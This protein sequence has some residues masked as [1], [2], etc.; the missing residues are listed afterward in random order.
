MRIPLDIIGSELRDS[1]ELRAQY[2]IAIETKEG[3]LDENVHLFV[4][5]AERSM[6]LVCTKEQVDDI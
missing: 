3:A 1:P 2:R 5:V 4:K 6:L